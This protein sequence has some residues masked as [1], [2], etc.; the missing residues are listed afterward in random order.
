MKSTAD[1]LKEQKMLEHLPEHCEIL[2]ANVDQLS[3]QEYAAARMG[4]FGASDASVILDVNPYKTREKL[5][6]EKAKAEVIELDKAIVRKG[7]DLEDY[8]LSRFIQET[9]RDTI[10]PPHMYRHRDL[11]FLSTNFD[12]I[13]I[14]N[15]VAIPV[16]IKLVSR[17]GEKYWNKNAPQCREVTRQSKAYAQHIKKMSE[18]CGIPAYYYTQVQ[19]Q[20]LL[21]GA[22]YAYLYACFDE[23]WTFQ[24][25]RILR[26]EFTISDLMM[27]AAQ[28]NRKYEKL[29]GEII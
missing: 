14:E 3:H 22:P 11:P 18:L 12:G 13:C 20:M 26:D 25:Y 24:C 4:T 17:F 21:S 29:K 8:I 28:V 16:E 6:I 19:Q 2:V 9:N 23:S 10:K 27:E 1:L 15:D 7:Y 5:V